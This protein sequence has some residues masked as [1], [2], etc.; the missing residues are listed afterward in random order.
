MTSNITYHLVY[1]TTNLLNGKIY[2]GKHTTK[3]LNDSYLGGGK[4]LKAAIKKH[5]R[6]NFKREILICA[7]SE[8]YA[9]ELE[10]E[11]VTTE[12]VKRKDVYNR[13]EGGGGPGHGE[14]HHLYGKPSA[15][16]GMH[17]TEETKRKISISATGQKH[18]DE[19]RKNNSLAKSG[20]KHPN[21]GK[22]GEGTPMYGRTGELNPMHGLKG[23]DHPAYGNKL[24]DEQRLKLSN[25]KRGKIKV[26]NGTENKMVNPNEIPEGFT[27][28]K[29][30]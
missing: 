6:G 25:A 18:T 3:N 12:F 28:V 2:V 19:H 10:A 17:H 11:I 9:F 27:R 20:E 4:V 23:K 13:I 30:V 7:L 21:W 15:R 22:R 16:L 5:G 24:T 14:N 1:Q 8:K 26:T 29:K